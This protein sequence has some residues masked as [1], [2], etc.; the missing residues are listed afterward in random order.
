MSLIE[1]V[2][3]CEGA[4]C[5]VD[6]IPFVDKAIVIIHIPLMGSYA[7]FYEKSYYGFMR[8]IASISHS[9]RMESIDVKGRCIMSL[10][11]SL[12][13]NYSEIIRELSEKEPRG[14]KR[15]FD[16]SISE[17][18]VAEV[19]STMREPKRRKIQAVKKSQPTELS[20]ILGEIFAELFPSHTFELDKRYT[21]EESGRSFK[22]NLICSSLQIAI[23]LS[24]YQNVD[25]DKYKN[26][27][28]TSLKMNHIHLKSFTKNRPRDVLKGYIKEQINSVV[29]DDRKEPA[30][31]H[32]L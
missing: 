26:E 9:T 25:L 31:I 18:D 1:L 13:E 4:V 21:R 14:K 28:C 32:V 7:L 6:V 15:S 5:S 12:K 10:S 30:I 17:K 27:L 23:S 2:S 3:L 22:F 8:S 24:P 11:F 19:L 29:P 20:I 16:E